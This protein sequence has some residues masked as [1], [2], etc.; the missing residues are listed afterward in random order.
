[1][2]AARIDEECER[3]RDAADVELSGENNVVVDALT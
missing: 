1:V 2:S 3:L